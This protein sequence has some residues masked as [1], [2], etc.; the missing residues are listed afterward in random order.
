MKF[1]T[2]LPKPSALALAA[3]AAAVMAC[4]TASAQTQFTG[5]T[6]GCFGA[7]CTPSSTYSPTA[8]V[9]DSS[10]LTYANSTFNVMSSAG[11]AGLG[12]S[13]STTPA[14]NV[15][16]LGSWSLTQQTFD[17]TGTPFKLLVSFSAPPGTTPGSA[18]FTSTLLGNV[19]LTDNGG[20]TVDF[21][22]TPRNFTFANGT[23]SLQVNDVSLTPL[24][25]ASPVASTGFILVS[26][27][28]EPETYA[29]FLAGLGAVGFM[30]RRRRS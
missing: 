24:A 28:P 16:N 30:A 7:A 3:A 2:R 22:N 5:F 11:F 9:F 20:V 4:G 21:D 19:G 8:S 6:S 14:S 23:F 17:Y 29:L 27:V 12:A 26:A 18:L 1:S 13:G 25:S 10:G 15:N